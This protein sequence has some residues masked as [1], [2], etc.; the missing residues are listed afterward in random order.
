MRERPS[1]LDPQVRAALEESI[2]RARKCTPSS[3][4]PT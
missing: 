3:A 4:A 1:M 2:E